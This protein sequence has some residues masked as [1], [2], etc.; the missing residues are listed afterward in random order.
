MQEVLF[1]A[2]VC[3]AV[4]PAN[5]TEFERILLPIAVPY[6]LPGAFGSR[7][8]THV[9]ARN[10]NDASVIIT[11]SPGGCLITVCPTREVGAK[12]TVTPEFGPAG[13]PGGFIWVSKPGNSRVELNLRVQDVSR[14]ALTW[15]TEIPVVREGDLRT[16][17]ITLLEIPTDSR[18][19]SALRVYDFD[20]SFNNRVR[21]RIYELF[22]NE[23]LADTFLTLG[24]PNGLE[25][26]AIPGIAQIGSL[27]DAFPGIANRRVRIEIT[28]DTPGLRFWAFV[29]V[30]NN[31][32]QHVTTITPQ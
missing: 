2:L 25:D 28:P 22:A 6:E 1:A 8:I 3:F 11:P 10:D 13:F 18:F 24:M 4:I 9:T 21:V 5:S 14:Q 31:E 32:T 23:T 15:G 16:D 7:W 17:T 27:T 20:G 29:S 19:R 12:T 26:S 30:T